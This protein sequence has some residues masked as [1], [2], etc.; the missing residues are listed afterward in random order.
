MFP[1]RSLRILVVCLISLNLGVVAS[2][3][4]PKKKVQVIKIALPSGDKM[5][6]KGSKSDL[7]KKLQSESQKRNSLEKQIAE[8]EPDACENLEEEYED[9]EAAVEAITKSLYTK[10]A[11]ASLLSPITKAEFRF[12]AS[13]VKF[14]IKLVENEIQ[15]LKDL[16]HPYLITYLASFEGSY[17]FKGGHTRQSSMEAFMNG[18]TD[19]IR[20]FNKTLPYFERLSTTKNVD[21]VLE[22]NISPRRSLEEIIK[23]SEETMKANLR[24]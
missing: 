21:R 3:A 11:D 5:V 6:L 19:Q 23:S 24:L 8:C 12:F 2:E 14:Q 1:S 18:L 17:M 22:I 20:F 4:A 9:S 7:F 10:A 16:T 15:E 13:E